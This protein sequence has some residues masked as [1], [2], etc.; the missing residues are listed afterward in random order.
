MID[1]IIRNL[2]SLGFA[3]GAGIL[4]GIALVVYIRPTEL[5]GIIILL[6]LATVACTTIGGLIAA[7]RGKKDAG[8]KLNDHDDGGE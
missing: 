4:L 1:T 7:L 3:G 5:G 2:S 8:R 6:V